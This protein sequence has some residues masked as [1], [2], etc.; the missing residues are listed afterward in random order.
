MYFKIYGQ[1]RTGT[2]YIS[3]LLLNNFL[4]TTRLE[5]LYPDIL[6]IKDAIKECL[7]LIKNKN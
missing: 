4:D 6:C 7:I 5:E 2:N 3:T 1:M